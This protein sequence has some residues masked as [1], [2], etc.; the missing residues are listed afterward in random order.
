MTMEKEKTMEKGSTIQPVRKAEE[1]QQPADKA[2]VSYEQLRDIANQLHQ[3]NMKL[4]QALM[5]QNYDNMFR[6]LDYLFK[7]LGH[8]DLFSEEFIASSIREI[9][10]IITIPKEEAE[11]TSEPEKEE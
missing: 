7:T 11:N 3:Q 8:A 10:D 6:R 9:E 4:R 1:T 5:K 2:P